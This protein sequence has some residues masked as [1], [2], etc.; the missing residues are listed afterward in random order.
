MTLVTAPRLATLSTLGLALIQLFSGCA[1]WR[2]ARATDRIEK[3]FPLIGPR[4]SVQNITGDLEVEAWDREEVSVV[5]EKESFGRTMEEARAD[6]ERVRVDVQQVDDGLSIIT[7]YPQGNSQTHVTYRL[8]APRRAR[9]DARLVTGDLAVSGIQ[10]GVIVD[11]TTG[12]VTLR[13][14]ASPVSAKVVTGRVRA[15][16]S[17]LATSVAI[18]T[19]TGAV[20][21]DLPPRAGARL[22]MATTTGSVRCGYDVVVTGDSV[23]GGRARGEINGGGPEVRVRVITGT[24]DVQP[25]TRG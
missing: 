25:S 19:V 7:R 18:E 22:D 10:G 6:L 23:I 15:T 8:R 11:V 3:T 20:T 16:L 13:D 1:A 4:V 2:T 17:N 12:D 9:I 5:A 21:L 24:I 14:I